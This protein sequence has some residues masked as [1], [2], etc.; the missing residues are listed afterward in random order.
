M[1]VF[2]TGSLVKVD[3]ASCHARWRAPLAMITSM[4]PNWDSNQVRLA[5]GL[6]AM[7]TTTAETTIAGKNQRAHTH[8]HTC[9]LY[10]A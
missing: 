7:S 4:C 9:I 3:V 5:P 6:C 8:A 2:H 10:P 1:S